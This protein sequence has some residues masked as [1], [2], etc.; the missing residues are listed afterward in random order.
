M[1]N[2]LGNR[3]STRSR[4]GLHAI[5]LVVPVVAIIAVVSFVASGQTS[6]PTVYKV[7]LEHVWIPMHDG[8]RLAA[9][10]YKPVNAPP[11]EKF[12]AILK[13]TPYRNDDNP[14]NQWDCHYAE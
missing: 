11:N 12:P 5:K 14:G 13:V 1:T 10:L 3:L 4:Q 8:V 6:P 9:W 7:K 2:Q